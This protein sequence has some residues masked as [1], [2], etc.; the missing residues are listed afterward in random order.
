MEPSDLVKLFKA[1]RESPWI[2]ILALLVLAIGI[3]L[4][5]FLTEWGRQM[6]NWV[7]QNEQ[8]QTS[9]RLMGIDGDQF[10]RNI[11]DST[12]LTCDNSD[13]ATFSITLGNSGNLRPAFNDNN[14]LYDGGCVVVVINDTRRCEISELTLTPWPH[15]P[16]NPRFLIEKKIAQEIRDQRISHQDLVMNAIIRCIRNELQSN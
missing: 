10:C 3:F 9:F 5:S 13:N 15:E 8:A 7:G 16:G 14:V 12:G 11:A 4:S 6:A 2:Y 1:A